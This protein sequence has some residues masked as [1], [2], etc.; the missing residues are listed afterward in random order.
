MSRET[1]RQHVVLLR[2]FLGDEGLQRL[3][4]QKLIAPEH[5]REQDPAARRHAPFQQT[6]ALN[7]QPR[8]GDFIPIVIDQPE[9]PQRPARRSPS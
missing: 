3:A 5:Q 7:R 8:L 2:A 6:S 4:K 1:I 9:F